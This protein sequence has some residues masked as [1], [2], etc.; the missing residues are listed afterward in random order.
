MAGDQESYSISANG[1]NQMPVM[2]Q[3][4][5]TAG[6]DWKNCERWDTKY[7]KTLIPLKCSSFLFE[8]SHYVKIN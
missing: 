8:M 2:L 5:L 6:L 3:V 4:L 7:I 1:N